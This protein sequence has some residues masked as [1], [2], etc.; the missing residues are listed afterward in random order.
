[1]LGLRVIGYYFV[2]NNM[3][4][5]VLFQPYLRKHILNFGKFLKDFKF[6]VRKPTSGN[7]YKTQLPS[8][9]KEIN[10]IK[11]SRINRLR[12]LFGIPNIRFKFDPEADIFFTYGCLLLT[13]KPYCVYVENGVALYN[14]DTKIAANPLA[15]F[16]VSWLIQKKNCIKVIFMSEAGQK[17]F[18][19]TV[20]YS[21]N[22]LAALEKKS[23]LLYP[24]IEK[25]DIESK[26]FSGTL[27]LLFAGTFYIKGGVEIARAFAKLR[28]KYNQVELTIIT[29]LHT[30][31]KEDIDWLQSIPG[32]NLLDAT[33]GEKEMNEMYASHDIFLL[34]TYRDGFGL[35]LVEAISWGMP[36][37]C[38]DQY[39]TTEV[40]VANY[41]AFVYPNHPM[42]DYNTE[43]F[44]LLGKYYNPRD[45]YSDLFR[46][47]KEGL[48]K[49]VEEFLR[50][51]I[52]NFLMDQTLLERF[53]RNSLELY[54]KKFHQDLISHRIE[55][56]F[57]EA[58]HP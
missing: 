44:E 2:N 6:V 56:V 30:I 17:S 19:A 43:T 3:Y 28:E 50:S 55:T 41:N 57:T 5:V 22:T 54:S 36:I 23:L 15:R 29:S 37:I 14:Y 9:D 1:M 40:A 27:K 53:S 20:P 26:R 39:A 8:Y 47:Q 58:I 13:N 7:F 33:F 12:R 10:R 34:P 42:K 51:S 11:T 25:K 21:P 49:P 52:E 24:L 46:F 38:T 48:L 32:L 18:F 16:F 35:V 31:K 45:F 4:K